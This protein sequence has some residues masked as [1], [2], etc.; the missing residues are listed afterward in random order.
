MAEEAPSNA[1]DFH[2]TDLWPLLGCFLLLQ[3]SGTRDRRNEMMT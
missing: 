3:N 2:D 1:H